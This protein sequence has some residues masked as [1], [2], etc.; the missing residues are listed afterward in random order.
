MKINF[1]NLM[2]IF[3]G[4]IG[5]LLVVISVFTTIFGGATETLV[6]RINLLSFS[7]GLLYLGFIVV[8]WKL[9]KK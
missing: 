6:L 4:I 2:L 1:I 8:V 9:I 7:I 3:L 5:L